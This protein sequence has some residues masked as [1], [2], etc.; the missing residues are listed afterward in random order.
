MKRIC[1]NRDGG[2]SI[3]VLLISGISIMLFLIMITET[4][5][6]FKDHLLSSSLR[7]QCDLILAEYDDV[8]YDRYG[9]FATPVNDTKENEFRSTVSGFCET[10]K[11]NVV[12]LERLEGEIL[13]RSIIRFAK[14][15][16]PVHLSVRFLD[17]ITALSNNGNKLTGIS[18]DNV[19]EISGE[20]IVSGTT[21]QSEFSEILDLISLV[22]GAEEKSSEGSGKWNSDISQEGL[23][24]VIDE[25]LE[26][27]DDQWS[28][29]LFA[30]GNS[31][32][33]GFISEIT[34]IAGKYFESDPGELYSRLSFEY[35]SS[36]MFSC[37]VNNTEDGTDKV[38]LRGSVTGSLL[39]GRTC[40]MERIV[41]GCDDEN[42]N[43][44]LA[45]TLIC[46]SRFVIHLLVN[47]TDPAER[48]EIKT[49]AASLSAAIA[50][51]SGGTVA[52]PPET[53]EGVL[54]IIISSSEAFSDWKEMLGGGRI[55]FI[56]ISS[57]DKIK[58]SYKD[59]M[60][61]MLLCVP[62]E[63]KL[64]RM[65]SL[66]ETASGHKSGLYTRIRSSCLYKGKLYSYED[67]Y[68]G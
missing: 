59:H 1:Y 43:K 7:R 37:R 40:E 49:A 33:Y 19:T 3:F 9:I 10:E 13:Y 39:S 31:P 65:S 53:I 62:M 30:V 16:F 44:N 55:P 22:L 21:G 15:R 54:L 45:Q 5:S 32:G 63:I 52:V 2:I 26:I 58:I 61:I 60:K 20:S 18:E 57:L 68:S 12:P 27:S 48:E 4:D 64:D 17:W 35:Y 51:V 34:G 6:A 42:R 36:E 29:G 38:D 8:I 46:G 11:Y 50:L 56:P 14:L 25:F 23:R 41:F 28:A 67:G 47:L 24:K 66:L